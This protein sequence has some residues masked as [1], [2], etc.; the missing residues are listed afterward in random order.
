MA[1]LV[2]DK[3][4]ERF[5]D[6]GVDHGILFEYSAG[7]YV[8]GVAWNGLVNVTQSPS[9]AEPNKQYAD[10]IVYVNLLSVEE[11]SATIEA[12][13]APPEFDKFNGLAKLANGVKLGQ[14]ARG[15]FAFYWRT[16]RGT[17]EN[18]EAG[19]VHHFAYGCQA[20]P[21]EKSNGTKTDTPELTSYSWSLSTT[22]VEVAGGRPTAYAEIDELDPDVNMANLV[23]LLE[24]VYG[25]AV[26]APRLPLPAELD[27]I[28][29]AGILTDTPAEPAFD[30]VDEITIPVDAGT[31]YYDITAGD[32]L[33]PDGA[34]T[35][36]VD[37]IVEARP[38]PGYTFT[39]VFVN[40]WLYNVA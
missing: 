29:G 12:F 38:A 3:L 13:M 26:N 19:Y 23:D 7:E 39:G 36:T 37:T 32:V 24:V 21:S 40:R 6:Q 17:A 31:N 5:F 14:Q 10:N 34:Y 22:P 33:I 11:F 25:D 16:I 2:W 15:M 20:S 30:G 1:E 4:D 8:N 35:I 28:L 27:T 18:P 9:G